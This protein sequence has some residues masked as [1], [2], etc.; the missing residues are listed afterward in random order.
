[1]PGPL[2]TTRTT[3]RCRSR[4]GGDLDAAGLGD[5]I[6]RVVDQVRPDLIQL[7]GEAAD[8]RQIGF[9]VDGHRDRLRS[10]LRLEHGD[11]VAQARRQID[12]L[13]HRGLVHVREA[14][15]RQRRGRRSASPPPESPTR[16]RG[17]SS[18]PRPTAAP[19][20]AAGRS[21]AP[22]DPVERLER[23]GG[24]GQ[25]PGDVGVDAVSRRA[26]RRWPP[27]VRPAGSATARR[28][29]RASRQDVRNAS[30]AA[31]CASVSCDAPSAR[32]A[33]SASSSRSSSSA[34]LRSIADA[35]L[36]SSC[37]RPADSLPSETIFSSCR[38]LDVKCAAAI[39]HRVD[40]DRRDLVA[41][42]NHRRAGRREG[43]RGSP[44]VPARPNRPA[45]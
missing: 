15:D 34:A 29:S 4:V 9:D 8:A 18:R 16:C 30:T 20:R 38:P 22:R 39:D 13:G 35:G 42:A 41:L 36:F 1:M 10:R 37:A 33:C 3:T 27:R 6:E 25:R 7:A 45:G 44:T 23:D 43:P 31:S 19:R 12:R 11:G 32:V 26:S 28:A 5:G 40:E 2:S 21:T 24:F 14:L 17:P